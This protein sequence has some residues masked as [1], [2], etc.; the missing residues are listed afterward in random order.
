[1]KLDGKILKLFP[2]I[3]ISLGPIILLA[4]PLFSGKSLFWGTPALQFVPWRAYA[5]DQIVSGKIPF[6][7]EYNGLV[8][9]LLA[10]Y[11]LAIF[12]PFSWISFPFFLL[13]DAPLM[14]WSN[15]IILGVHLI[16]SGIGMGKLIKQWGGTSAGMIAGGLAFCL[17]GFWVCRLG[18]FTMIWSGAW[19]PWEMYLVNRLL[20]SENDHKKIIG[21]FIKLTIVEAFQLLA[22]HAQITWYCFVLMAVWALVSVVLNRKNTNPIKKIFLFSASVFLAVG[23]SSI[24]LF[25]TAEFL[26]QSQRSESVDYVKALAYSF[27]PWHLLNFLAPNLFGSPSAGDYWGYA[28]Y[29]EDAVYIAIMP[30]L[31]AISTVFYLFKPANIFVDRPEQWIKYKMLVIFGWLSVFIAILLAL[32]SNTVIF[33]FLFKTIPTFDMFNAPAR[34]M[35]VAVFFMCWLAGMGISCWAK[36]R[37]KQK[38]WIKRL[39]V[40]G[41]SLVLG[42]IIARLTL[43]WIKA[44]FFFPVA[45]LGISI[46][47]TFWLMLTQPDPDKLK[48]WEVYVFTFV[49]LDLLLPGIGFNPY[50]G[51]SFYQ[52][53]S[54]STLE[55]NGR[56]FLD[57]K[58]E[59]LLKFSKYLRFND[60]SA[61]GDWQLMREARLPDI[62]MLDK[63]YS[64]SNFDPLLSG[65]FQSWL[66]RYDNAGDLQKDHMLDDMDVGTL[67][68]TEL[69][70]PANGVNPIQK[71]HSGP[72]RW[73]GCSKMAN[74][75][76]DALDL[77]INNPDRGVVITE[78]SQPFIVDSP[79]G[80]CDSNQRALLIKKM[81]GEDLLISIKSAAPGW[82]WASYLFYPG[83]EVFI[84]GIEAQPQRVNYLFMG[85]QVLAG[86]HLIE[87]HYRP[88]LFSWGLFISLASCC[89]LM[90]LKIVQFK[91]KQ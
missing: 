57:Q 67:L 23:V 49:L 59:Y 13:G 54:N 4:Y 73:A 36:P 10:N 88:I 29:W 76:Q 69:S 35:V 47:I 25:P 15:N 80:N 72:V 21:I 44:T 3:L 8:A 52:R 16:L 24:Q 66:D 63:T 34:I 87:F 46:S 60:F 71:A 84:D 79:H 68:V 82:V 6:L 64:A 39:M 14:A 7:N 22:G 18:F 38:K 1:M 58:N 2:Y 43:P 51:N 27:W 62:N 40:I 41:I 31:G 83:W 30:L 5:Y 91:S 9:P 28:S 74:A 65:R 42:V 81:T 77:T 45:L 26:L 50:I 75:P 17:S 32:G 37:S 89:I 19:L 86:E 85:T 33:P 12:Y 56:Y 48:K 55:Y 53:N 90:V 70:G 78:S 11:Q 20:A 61:P